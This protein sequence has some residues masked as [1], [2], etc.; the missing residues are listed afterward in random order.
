MLKATFPL[1]GIGADNLESAPLGIGANFG[2]LIIGRIFLMIG[3]H[4]DIF[5]CPFG[6]LSDL[7]RPYLSSTQ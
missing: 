1:V 7:A 3:G 2:G 4:A 5:G 6:G